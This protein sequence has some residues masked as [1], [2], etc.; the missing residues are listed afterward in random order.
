MNYSYAPYNFIPFTPSVKTPVAYSDRED[1]PVHDVFLDDRLSGRIEYDITAL[2]DIIVGG[3]ASD[4]NNKKFFKNGQGQ[5]AIPGSTMRGFFRT[6]AEILSFSYPDM[7]EDKVFLY[8]KFADACVKLRNEYSSRMK[9]DENSEYGIPAGVK[10]GYIY[11]KKEKEG[12]CYY[13]RPVKQFG[14]LGTTFFKVH[15]NTLRK[16]GVLSGHSMYTEELPPFKPSSSQNALDEYKK[17]YIPILQGMK[18]TNYK[19][20]RSNRMIKFDYKEGHLTGINNDKSPYSG[21]LLNSSYIDGKTHHYFVSADIN[22]SVN[23]IRINDMYI[24]AYRNDLERNRI[25]NRNLKHPF[26]SLDEKDIKVKNNDE[27][28]KKGKLFFYKVNSDGTLLGFGPTPYFRILYKNPVK[29]GIPYNVESGYDYVKAMFGYA[30]KGES[31]KSRISFQNAVAHSV[32]GTDS[33]CMMVSGTPRGTAVQMYLDQTGKNETNLKSYNDDDFLL[34]GYKVYWKRSNPIEYKSNKDNM[35]ATYEMVKAG[36]V[37]SGSIYFNNLSREELGLLLLSIQYKNPEEEKRDE[38]YLIGGAKAYG[39]GKIKLDNIRLYTDDTRKSFININVIENKKTV[40]DIEG[41]KNDYK[42]SLKNTYEI[43]LEKTATFR[44]YKAYAM[45]SKVDEY[46]KAY[47]TGYMKISRKA[48]KINPT[49]PDRYPLADIETILKENLNAESEVSSKTIDVLWRSCKKPDSNVKK[50][51]E[52]HLGTKVNLISSSET[53][54]LINVKKYDYKTIVFDEVRI[55]KDE[56]NCLKE[57]GRIVLQ[58]ERNQV[59]EK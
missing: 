15:E 46:V 30:G 33:K 3:A 47:D 53:I 34:G 38:T 10:A 26:Y 39:F 5:Y 35:N 19:A 4:K 14:S 41:Y 31:Y 27:I 57:D 20:Y 45:Q 52:K 44:V 37:F 43:D 55:S 56:I 40:D 13:I 59:V 54:N 28:T 21:V 2:T 42:E 18:N 29:K 22:T 32:I 6:H 8:R 16:S 36:T 48:D 25:Q 51:I 9:V 24:E 7:I 58:I 1:L 50:L 17:Q 11:C 23:S 49:Y 12:V